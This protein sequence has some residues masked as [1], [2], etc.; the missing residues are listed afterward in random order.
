MLFVTGDFPA[1]S[2]VLGF[3]GHNAKFPCR[4]CLKE[5]IYIKD[6]RASYLLPVGNEICRTHAIKGLDLAQG[7]SWLD[8]ECPARRTTEETMKVW[9]LLSDQNDANGRDST[10]RLRDDLS[11]RTGIKRKPTIS[12][13][14]L[15]FVRCFPYDP[16]HQC[17]L[18]WVKLLMTLSSGQHKKNASLSSS[19]V[20][21]NNVLSQID[22]CLDGGLYGIPSVWGRPPL[23]LEFLRDYKAEDFKLFGMLYGTL[24]FSGPEVDR[25]LSHLWFLTSKFLSIVFDP[26]PNVQTVSTLRMTVQAAHALFAEVFYTDTRHAFC[27]TPTTH[28]ILH[29]PDMLRDC[30]PLTN[31]SQFVIER[32]V[33]ELGVYA[34]SRRKPEAN[35]FHKTY[36]LFGLR[37]LS[38]GLETRNLS[39]LEQRNMIETDVPFHNGV[40][41]DG[42]PLYVKV[43]KGIPAVGKQRVD[44]AL[45]YLLVCAPE[46]ISCISI[47]AVKMHDNI[48]IQEAGHN[49]KI[50]TVGAFTTREQKS[51]YRARQR[52]CVAAH[53]FEESDNSV[54][55]FYGYVNEIWEV[56]YSYM[57]AAKASHEETTFLVRADW[58][59]ELEIDEEFQ[60]VYSGNKGNKKMRKPKI[61]F[62]SVEHVICIKRLIAFLDIRDRRYYIDQRLH[63]FAL[64]T[65]DEGMKLM[66]TMLD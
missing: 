16:M 66:G 50:E 51:C 38:N 61:C 30:G 40:G 34:K 63:D 57:D 7:E 6:L 2:K 23:S 59:Y 42:Y 24:L 4:A 49:L 26:T 54:L 44:Q 15:D 35:L 22:T 32:L 45:E 64:L 39:D 43:K 12:R 21:N 41:G 17:L 65:G 14:T 46:N 8:L 11:K 9:E 1:V 3:R 27:Y 20:V 55:T 36:T 37:L 58:A 62:R 28:S 53:F 13:L 60:L 33:G 19:Y 5:A 47:V 29:L 56:Q 10:Y 48:T 18:G 25:R 52:F 31:V